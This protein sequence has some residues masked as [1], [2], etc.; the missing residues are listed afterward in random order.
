MLLGI[1]SLLAAYP[2]SAASITIGDIVTTS[3]TTT[4]TGRQAQTF[5][6]P[7][8]M[9][10][11]TAAKVSRY[12]YSAGDLSITRSFGGS[13]ISPITSIAAR[14][15]TFISVETLDIPAAGIAITPGEVLYLEVSTGSIGITHDYYAE[16]QINGS[17]TNDALFSV[18]FD[19]QPIATAVPTTSQWT[20]ALM[21]MTLAGAAASMLLWRER[22][23][24]LLP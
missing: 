6:V 19:D 16:G 21:V 14:G 2:A 5:T 24:K 4:H 18:T 7:A 22:R 12:G 3:I 15:E 17:S 1:L 8:G 23:H 9:R 10:R 11:I 20:I 13:A